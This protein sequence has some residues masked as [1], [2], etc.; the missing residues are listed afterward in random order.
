MKIK[1]ILQVVV[2][3]E[4]ENKKDAKGFLKEMKAKI[5]DYKAGYS[6]GNISVTKVKILE[7]EGDKA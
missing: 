7:D 3:I 4:S 6:T 2:K 1:K 5:L